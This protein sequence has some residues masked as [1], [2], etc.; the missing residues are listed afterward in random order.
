[1]GRLGTRRGGLQHSL[2]SVSIDFFLLIAPQGPPLSITVKNSSSTSLKLT[3]KPIEKQLQFGLLLGYRIFYKKEFLAARRKRRNA[4]DI[5][6]VK[7]KLAWNLEGLEI[8]TKYCIQMAG[9]NSKGNGNLSEWFCTSTDEDG[10][11]YTN[12][13]MTILPP[14]PPFSNSLS[15]HSQPPDLDALLIGSCPSLN[16]LE[17]LRQ[18]LSCLETCLNFYTEENIYFVPHKLQFTPKHSLIKTPTRHKNSSSFTIL[19]SLRTTWRQ[20]VV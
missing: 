13:R 7:D 5:V 4:E 11:Q 3:W 8:F 19:V 20:I 12:E 16:P 1:M 6:E 9:F 2:L 14:L 10:K 18:F 17:Q 15:V